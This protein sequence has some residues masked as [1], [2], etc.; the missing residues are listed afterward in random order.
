M[1][2]N[3]MKQQW[4]KEYGILLNKYELVIKDF[5]KLTWD[6][7]LKLYDLLETKRKINRIYGND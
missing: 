2:T 4:I 6:E 7:F 3:E 5:P 1:V